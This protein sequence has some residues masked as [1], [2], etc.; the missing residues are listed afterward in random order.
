MIAHREPPKKLDAEALC[1]FA[2][3]IQKRLVGLVVGAQQELS[4]RAPPRD[5]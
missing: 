2:K 5:D 3:A 1:C 4:L